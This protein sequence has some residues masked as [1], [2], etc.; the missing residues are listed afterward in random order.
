MN[1]P[2]PVIP[3]GVILLIIGFV[4]AIAPSVLH[5]GVPHEYAWATGAFISLGLALLCLSVKHWISVSISGLSFL[6]FAV[7]VFYVLK[8]MLER[9]QSIP[10]R[11]LELAKTIPRMCHIPEVCSSRNC[12]LQPRLN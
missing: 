8:P 12:P 1:R 5:V 10:V 6:V 3:S 2:N 11:L 7:C 4:M 9:L